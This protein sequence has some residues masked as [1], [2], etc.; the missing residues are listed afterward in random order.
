MGITTI[1]MQIS[2][3][4]SA[5]SGFA[6]SVECVKASC[7]SGH[8]SLQRAENA[9]VVD[10]SGE[11]IEAIVGCHKLGVHLGFK[12][13]VSLLA[14]DSDLSKGNMPAAT[15]SEAAAHQS[16]QAGVEKWRRQVRQGWGR[17]RPWRRPPCDQGKETRCLNGT[18][19]SHDRW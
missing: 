5:C 3:R 1:G 4:H 13:V 15:A 14:V 2:C 9:D 7:K 19:G 10:T 12:V 17:Y 6:L 11:S 8:R 16:L 18:V